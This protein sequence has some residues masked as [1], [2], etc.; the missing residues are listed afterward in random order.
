MVVIPGHYV[1]K[2]KKKI[3]QVPLVSM[4]TCNYPMI[5]HFCAMIDGTFWEEKNLRESY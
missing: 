5:E 4:A 1:G 3:L 2:E